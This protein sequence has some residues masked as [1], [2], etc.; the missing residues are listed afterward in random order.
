MVAAHSRWH[1][2]AAAPHSLRSLFLA[3]GRTS[4]AD[5]IEEISRRLTMH[6][7]DAL[8]TLAGMVPALAAEAQAGRLSI[9]PKAVVC[10]AELLPPD[11]RRLIKETWNVEPYD[12]YAATEA[13]SIAA[14]CP[15]HNGLHLYEDLIIPEVVDEDNQPVPAGTPGAKLLITQ[16]YSR[17]V[18]LIR[19]QLDDSVTLSAGMCECGRPF[20]RL[21]RIEGRIA[22]TLRFER[23]DGTFAVLHPVR[24]GTIFDT[25][26]LKGWQVV[27]RP[28]RLTISVLTP[29]AANVAAEVL[30]RVDHL[31][32]DLG[33]ENITVDLQEV[34]DI[35]KH[36]SG[37]AVLVKDESGPPV[38][39]WDKPAEQAA[40]A[41]TGTTPDHDMRRYARK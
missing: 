22:E 29:V 26:A 5:P 32:R 8:V 1:Q 28:H 37:K 9:R 24:F 14:E 23:A 25:L 31:L 19:Y 6:K 17:T 3:V 16:L 15:Q 21:S 12:M 40:R 41:E 35:P 11:S 30:N 4:P 39:V 18:P 2:S 10:V 20:Q 34:A 38:V 36:R 27:R 13:A 33:V 7:P